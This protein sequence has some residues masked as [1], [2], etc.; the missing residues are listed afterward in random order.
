MLTSD[1][2]P[3]D[4]FEDNVVS[5]RRR[6]NLKNIFNGKLSHDNQVRPWWNSI[7]QNYDRRPTKLGSIDGSSRTEK[8]PQWM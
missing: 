6:V 1:K 3:S 7:L 2:T 5:R 8:W 4:T